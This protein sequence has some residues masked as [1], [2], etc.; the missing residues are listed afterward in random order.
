MGLRLRQKTR[1]NSLSKKDNLLHTF[2]LRMGFGLRQNTRSNSLIKKKKLQKQMLQTLQ[3]RMGFGFRQ[4]T[5]SN[6]L[7]KKTK[8]AKKK[9]CIPSNYAWDL[10][11]GRIRDQTHS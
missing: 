3:L 1:S 4:N 10:A 9:C 8:V 11:S 7:I 5:R 2:H 6:S